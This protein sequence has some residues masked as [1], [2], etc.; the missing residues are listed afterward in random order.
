MS[1]LSLEYLKVLEGWIKEQLHNPE[2][3]HAF[4][5]TRSTWVEM[6]T[7]ELTDPFTD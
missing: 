6:R 3:Q 2:K 4:V 5:F 7:H 1:E